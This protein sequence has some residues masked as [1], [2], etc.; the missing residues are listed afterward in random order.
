MRSTFKF[1]RI[2]FAY[3][4]HVWP[5]VLLSDLVESDIA[6]FIVSLQNMTLFVSP[7]WTRCLT[8]R[9]F[10]TFSDITFIWYYDQNSIHFFKSIWLTMHYFKEHGIS[11]SS[12]NAKRKNSGFSNTFGTIVSLKKLATVSESINWS[13]W[14][15][16]SPNTKRK[17]MDS[18][19]SIF[20]TRCHTQTMNRKGIM[21]TAYLTTSKMW[22]HKQM[23]GQ[24][25]IC[26]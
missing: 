9:S 21:D 10:K 1:R 14:L 11:F 3:L 6:S 5:Y 22:P 20:L 17:Q 24:N 26:I 7:W 4:G 8:V 13:F 25:L 19:F 12:K 15:R 18:W 23:C 2:W 16:Q